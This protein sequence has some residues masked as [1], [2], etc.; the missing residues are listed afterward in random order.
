MSQYILSV[1]MLTLWVVVLVF[2]FFVFD[3]AILKDYFKK[4]L[5]KRFRVEE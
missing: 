4:K 1:M 5:Q 3:N 2:F